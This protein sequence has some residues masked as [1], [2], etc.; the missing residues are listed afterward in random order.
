VNAELGEAVVVVVRRDDQ[1]LI[2]QR[3]LDIQGGGY[4]APPSGR[5]EPGET[6]AE[7]AMRE[8]LE[9]TGLTVAPTCKVWECVS[10]SGTYLLHWWLA[11]YVSGELMLQASEVNDAR[12]LTL[13]EYA[14]L[15][16]IFEADLEFFEQVF[17][18][19]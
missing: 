15:E 11:D 17:P 5:V 19:L 3:A 10:A 16:P 13:T 2:I 4:W 18:E 7:A 9:E 8:I 14:A 6:Q 1:I 12:W